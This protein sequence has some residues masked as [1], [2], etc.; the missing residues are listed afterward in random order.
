MSSPRGD[1]S[2]YIAFM[3]RGLRALARR[4][5]DAD[6]EDL[7]EMLTLRDELDVAIA[8][9]VQGVRRSGFSWSDIGRATGMTRQSA[10]GRWAS[11]AP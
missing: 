8:T 5:G 10:H 7:A 9:A 4:V 1:H 11:G 2:E 6:P 3:R